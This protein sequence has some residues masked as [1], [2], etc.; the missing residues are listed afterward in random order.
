MAE[1]KQLQLSVVRKDEKTRRVF[2]WFSIA[3][4]K[5]DKPLIDRHGDVIAVEDLEKAADEFVRSWR[6]GGED[7]RGPAPNDLIASIV[8]TRE[9]QDAIGVPPGVLP[10]GW[11]GGFRVSEEA[12]QRIAKGDLLMFSI[13]G[14]AET[15]QV[16]VDGVTEV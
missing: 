2:G 9:L 3:K 5:D 4:T 7:H 14:E 15:E 6:Q 13:E 10:Q 12:F 1:V 11:L 16:E 8:L